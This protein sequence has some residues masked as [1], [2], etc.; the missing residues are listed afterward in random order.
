MSGTSSAAAQEKTPSCA[1]GSIGTGER[2]GPAAKAQP[3]P[4]HAGRP[5]ERGS[6]H[7]K[8]LVVGKIPTTE[9]C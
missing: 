8:T 9:Q 3:L 7:G 4:K 1:A 2:T 5:Q 6:E